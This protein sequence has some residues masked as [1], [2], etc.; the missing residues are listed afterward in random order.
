[1]AFGVG[2]VAGLGTALLLTSHRREQAASCGTL[3]HSRER[4]GR[5]LSDA[6]MTVL[7]QS[8]GGKR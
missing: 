3:R 4:L 8:L 7:P 2:L 6:I 1:M 5:Q